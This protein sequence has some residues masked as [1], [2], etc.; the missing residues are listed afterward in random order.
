M[1][2][3]LN[4]CINFEIVALFTCK[5]VLGKSQFQTL[6]AGENNVYIV[7]W[8]KGKGKGKTIPVNA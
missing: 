8:Y 2:S 3:E 4:H 5:H 7:A 1:T 6:R